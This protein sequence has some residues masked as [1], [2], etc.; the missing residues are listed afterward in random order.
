MNKLYI[1]YAQAREKQETL[2]KVV[3]VLQVYL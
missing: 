1:C 2:Q 3:M